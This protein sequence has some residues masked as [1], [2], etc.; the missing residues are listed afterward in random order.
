MING[1]VIM[2]YIGVIV[3]FL[4]FV[5]LI[6]YSAASVSGRCSDYERFYFDDKVH[7]DDRRD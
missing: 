1:G 5:V 2:E 6:A 7:T 3:V 4:V